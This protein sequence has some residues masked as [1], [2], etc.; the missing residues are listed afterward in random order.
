MTRPT[1]PAAVV[2]ALGIT[3]I[4]GYGTLYY[5]FSTLAPQMGRDLGLPEAWIFAALSV[6]LF[7]GSLFAPQAGRWADRYGA[8]RLMAFGSVLASVALVAAALAPEKISFVLALVAMEVAGCFVLYGTAFVAV[9]QTG[10]AKGKT[11][12]THLTLIAGFASTLFW[13]LTDWLAA[14]FDWRSIYLLFAGLNLFICLPLHGWIARF[15]AD[16]EGRGS[17]TTS[18]P[19]SEQPVTGPSPTRQALAERLFPLMLAGFALQG[20]VLSAILVHM[21][22]LVTAL[23]SGT[24][25]VYVSMVFGPAQVLSRLVNMVL[26]ATLV[27][28]RLAVIA[29]AMLPLA[30]LILLLS[31]PFIP[32]VLVF[33]A[34][35]GLGSG[36]ISIVGGTLPLELYGRQGYGRRLGVVTAA[37]QVSAAFAPFAL[38]AMMAGLGIL[39]SLGALFTL[40]MIEFSAFVAIAL[41]WARA[42]A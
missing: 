36:L 28:T 21:V 16:L 30:L 26:G 34:L 23:G 32:G 7:L 3:Q 1:S 11:G 22:P 25:G 10:G 33:V 9:V 8:G 12:I 4:I 41:L 20:F 14:H 27:Q 31:A 15:P 37:R 17:P 2:V 6:S 39:P 40:G 29:A 18:T 42:A 35:T 24:A 38:S 13:P 19:A 5:S